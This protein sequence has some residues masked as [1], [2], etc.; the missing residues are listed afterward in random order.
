RRSAVCEDPS[1]RSRNRP[2]LRQ[3][4]SQMSMD[5]GLQERQRRAGVT[6]SK[7]RQVNE[8]IE[9]RHDSSTFAEYTCECTQKTC[10]ATISLSIDEYEE[11]RKVS[12]HFVVAPG[13]GTPGVERVV[14]E[15]PRYHVVEKFGQ[16]GQVASLL[17][18]R[19]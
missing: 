11:V 8:V 7:F 5:E 16:A 6:E 18:P 1:P 9:L 2:W 4:G 10:E 17:N 3:G 12:T 13:H 19:S 15:T 14:R